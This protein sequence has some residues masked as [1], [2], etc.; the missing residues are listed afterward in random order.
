MKRSI[1][2]LCM[3]LFSMLLPYFTPT[4]SACSCVE[5]FSVQE[6]LES[7]ALVI[8]GTVREIKQSSSAGNK[9]VLVEVSRIFK[10]ET[11]SQQ[12]IV[13]AGDS[14]ACGF[15][16]QQGLDHLI[17]ARDVGTGYTT[18]LCD[19][20]TLASS[21]ADDLSILGEGQLP[22]EQVELSLDRTPISFWL[23]GIPLLLG[24]G[25]VVYY[26]MRRKSS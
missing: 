7:S 13:T 9:E 5:P 21:A 11:Q 4:A 16:F 22:D 12:I 17:Y 26:F 25:I 3:M 8:L 10:G 6:E 15:E 1:L 14:A 2:V 23:I 20:T 19:R 18:G 24:L